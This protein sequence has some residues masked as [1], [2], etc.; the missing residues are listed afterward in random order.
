MASSGAVVSLNEAL[1]YH[2]ESCGSCRT[3]DKCREISCKNR[4][5]GL[6]V[7]AVDLLTINDRDIRKVFLNGHKL[8]QLTDIPL[9]WKKY[10]L[11]KIGQRDIVQGTE[12][13]SMLELEEAV[14]KGQ[15]V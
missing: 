10:L 5:F 3:K 12:L 15:V 6:F 4:Y 1:N 13:L 11:C 2:V 8:T 9:G 14:E 7:H